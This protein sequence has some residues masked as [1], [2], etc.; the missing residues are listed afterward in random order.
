MLVSLLA[1]LKSGGAYVP[2]DPTYPRERLSLMI[3]DAQARVLLTHE[4]WRELVPEYGTNVV[5]LDTD[6]ETIAR[7]PVGNPS[8]DA[9]SVTNQAFIIYTSG[10]TGKPNGVMVTHGGFAS[11]IEAFNE[12]YQITSADRLLQFA[13]LSFDQRRRDL[14]V[15]DERCDGGA[16]RR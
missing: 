16:A 3:A 8:R 13:S 9:L 15:A 14:C 4:R 10:S 7:E 6:W 2:L 5:C 12:T 1:T 11:Y